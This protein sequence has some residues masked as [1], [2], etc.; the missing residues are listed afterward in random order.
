MSVAHPGAVFQSKNQASE[1][2]GSVIPMMHYERGG[3][4]LRG[5]CS[6][7]VATGQVPG[8]RG[9]EAEMEFGSNQTHQVGRNSVPYAAPV[10][11]WPE[12]DSSF[13]VSVTAITV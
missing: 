6:R 2:P 3:T 1:V 10:S 7:T 4:G 9:C 5:S 8:F 11:R 12:S 13:R